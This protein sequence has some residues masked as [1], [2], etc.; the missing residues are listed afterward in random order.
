MHKNLSSLLGKL[1]QPAPGSSLSEA[2]RTLPEA[3]QV[4]TAEELSILRGGDKEYKPM[5]D[6]P[7][8]NNW[9]KPTMLLKLFD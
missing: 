5:Y 9:F 3:I 4:V 7:E 2:E 1:N 6:E 8:D